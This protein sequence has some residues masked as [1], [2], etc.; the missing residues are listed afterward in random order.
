MDSRRRDVSAFGFY[1]LSLDLV[2]GA[3]RAT[4]GKLARRRSD[5]VN[6]NSVQLLAV[7]SCHYDSLRYGSQVTITSIPSSYSLSVPVIHYAATPAMYR[8]AS[9]SQRRFP[10]RYTPLLCSG[11]SRL[12]CDRIPR[13][14]LPLPFYFQQRVSRRYPPRLLLSMA[15]IKTEL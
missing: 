1:R 10:R 8:R 2:P 14:A 4:F 3:H 7:R 15:A 6:D 12:A 11:I 9:I 5:A 13:S